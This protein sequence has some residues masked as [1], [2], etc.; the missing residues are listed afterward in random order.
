M[1]SLSFNMQRNELPQGIK[2]QYRIY[3]FEKTNLQDGKQ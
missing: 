1:D 3:S 2:L